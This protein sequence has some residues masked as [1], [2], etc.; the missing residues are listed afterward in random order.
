MYFGVQV[1]VAATWFSHNLS[2][3]H[4]S[5]HKWFII[6]KAIFFLKSFKRF[7]FSELCMETE[8]EEE[9]DGGI[10]VSLANDIK[11]HLFNYK[12]SGY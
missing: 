5:P 2:T 4:S 12:K 8:K 10:K 9:E 7:I 6:F 11:N 1:C 3:L